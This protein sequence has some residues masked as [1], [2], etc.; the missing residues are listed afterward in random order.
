M[1]EIFGIEHSKFRIA[2][3]IWYSVTIFNKREIYFYFINFII[4]FKFKKSASNLRN[5]KSPNVNEHWQRKKLVKKVSLKRANSLDDY[6]KPTSNTNKLASSSSSSS[7]ST[8]SPLSSSSSPSSSRSSLNNTASKKNKTNYNKQQQAVTNVTNVYVDDKTG[9]KTQET[10]K[11]FKYKTSSESSITQTTTITKTSNFSG[12]DENGG[13]FELPDLKAFYD[14]EKLA[15]DLA[16]VA[17][18]SNPTN[19]PSASIVNRATETT[20]TTTNIDQK[21]FTNEKCNF[22]LDQFE[23]FAKKLQRKEKLLGE[24]L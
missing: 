19:S 14:L 13:V 7:P 2:W 24:L 1:F 4:K 9:T 18:A 15:I 22:L 11:T 20:Q 16:T 6:N 23:N 10:I 3:T 17:A 5:K 12:G 21:P 8:S